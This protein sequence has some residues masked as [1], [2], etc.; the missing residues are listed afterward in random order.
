MTDDHEALRRL[1]EEEGDEELL[2][3]LVDAG[4]G[5]AADRWAEIASARGDLDL[6]QRMADEGSDA[7]ER[8]LHP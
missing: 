6:V 2:G 1:V 8:L 5:P 7:A 4:H 3:W